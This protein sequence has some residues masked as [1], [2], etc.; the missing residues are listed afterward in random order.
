MNSGNFR[1]DTYIAAGPVTYGVLTNIIQDEI[2]VKKVKGDRLLM[3][4]E[5]CVSMYPNLSGR[6]STFSGI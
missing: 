6:Y 3:G 2:V 1:A 5:N 4:L